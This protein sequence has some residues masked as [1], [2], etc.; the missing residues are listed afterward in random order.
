M[1][2]VMRL[3][4]KDGVGVS[5][6]DRVKVLSG[7][8]E[9]G[10]LVNPKAYRTRLPAFK[11]VWPWTGYLTLF[12]SVSPPVKSHKVYYGNLYLLLW[13]PESFSED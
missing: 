12:V 3:L 11:A 10:G 13:K 7:W 8:Q 4:G 1:G 5:S 9:F 6:C 2:V